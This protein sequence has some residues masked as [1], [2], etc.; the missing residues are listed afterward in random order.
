MLRSVRTVLALGVAWSQSASAQIDAPRVRLVED[1]R[2]DANAEDFPTVGRIYVGPRGQIAVPIT[3]DQQLRIYD[4]NGK[5]VAVFGR[6]GGGPG[7]F[8]FISF[9]GWKSD[10]IWVQDIEQRRTT[11]FGVDYKL[12]RTEPWPMVD[13]QT[14]EPGRIGAFDPLALLPDGSWLGQGFL[15]T[16]DRSSRQGVLAVR[17]SD[18]TYRIAL[19]MPPSERDSRMMWVSG[20]G[21]SVPFSLQPQY[22]FP[23]DA[24]RFGELTAPLPT[25]DRSHFT[26]TVF[27]ATGDTIFSRRYEFRGVPIPRQ[28]KDSALAAMLPRGGRVSEGPQDLP[29]RF[30][31]LARERMSS[32]YIPAET[33]T[34]GL[35]HTIW[36]G[37][38]LSDSG[39][40]YLILNGRGDPIGSLLLPRSS[41]LRQANAT[42]I[43]VT[44]TDDDGLTSV[45]RYR[46]QALRCGAIPC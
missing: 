42:H 21:R 6:K 3:V 12:L 41:R 16:A 27:R 39:R 25:S 14:T 40:E 23:W 43:W 36:I 28:A 18:G 19:R 9:V 1:L 20:F 22:S 24:S 8:G 38:R 34:L 30:Q 44:D 29:Q 37:M 26:V 5:K 46:I 4:G 11:Y 31:A 15:A 35:D 33:I 10:S 45:V 7:E 2:L 32:W 17:S 13:L